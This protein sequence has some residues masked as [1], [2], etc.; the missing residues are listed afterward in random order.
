MRG[1]ARSVEADRRVVRFPF[2]SVRVAVFRRVSRFHVV[3]HMAR[4]RQEWRST[5][6]SR[7]GAAAAWVDL[8]PSMGWRGGCCVVA[9]TGFGVPTIQV[10]AVV[11]DLVNS[12][13]WK[14]VG[15]FV[16]ENSLVIQAKHSTRRDWGT[17]VMVIASTGVFVLN[18]G[19]QS[20]VAQQNGCAVMCGAGAIAEGEAACGD[21]DFACVTSVDCPNGEACEGGWCVYDDTFDGGCAASIPS[22]LPI[23]C[24]QEYCGSA[25]TF[26]G[27]NCSCAPPEDVTGDGVFDLLDLMCVLDALTGDF[28]TCPMSVVDVAPCGGNGKVNL[29]DVLAVVGAI[30]GLPGCCGPIPVGRDADWYELVLATDTLITWSGSAEFLARYQ[31]VAA[32]LPGA[33]CSDVAVVAD[34]VAAPCEPG[35]VSAC[36]QAGTYFLGISPVDPLGV[37]CDSAY[38]VRADCDS[39]ALL[40]GPGDGDCCDS[41]GNGTAGCNDGSCCSLVC[42][43]QPSCCS[44]EWDASCAALAKGM[45]SACPA[46][47]ADECVNA[48]PVEVPS[49]SPG[50]TVGMGIDVAPT[51]SNIGVDSPGVWYSVMGTGN[52]LSASICGSANYDSKIS[53]YCAGCDTLNCISGN[54]DLL[55]CGFTSRVNWCSQVGTEYLILVH[56]AVGDSGDFVLDVFDD[57]A[58]CS[59]AP[60]CGVAICG[61]GV[62]GFG[63]QCDDGNTTPGDGCDATCMLEPPPNDDCAN[64]PLITEADTP[65][66]FDNFAASTDGVSHT[67]CLF[68]GN[69][70]IFDDVW[71]D[72]VA[73][74]TGTAIVTTCDSAFDTKVAVYDGCG[75]PAG[76]PA[77]IGCD[78]DTCGLQSR[79][80][81]AATQG[82]CYKIRV[83]GGVPTEMGVGSG[84]LQITC[85]SVIPEGACCID[86]ACDSTGTEANCTAA[87]GIW[88]IGQSCPQF[89]CPAPNDEC[90]GRTLLTCGTAT[91]VDTTNGT[92]N[93]NDPPGSCWIGAGAGSVFL[94][95]VADA[96][97][98]RVRTDSA[99]AIGNAVDSEYVVFA[100]DQANPCDQSLWT[101]VGCSEDDGAG[102]LGDICVTGLTV[103]DR[104][105]IELGSFASGFQGQYTVEINCPCSPG[106]DSPGR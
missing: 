105:I 50:T 70:Q 54:D 9:S 53:A 74:C 41:V 59:T 103:G 47:P 11:A 93:A 96:S 3:R 30:R 36:V 37:A 10:I 77:K 78:D 55:G 87:G 27:G 40:C 48:T 62:V 73:E 60:D 65:L 57:G 101:Q 5:G 46:P 33:E 2:L 81:F 52:T 68:G 64:A 31:I 45:C 94:E 56:G 89:V 38:T 72:H 20:S 67:T 102:L 79:V 76:D 83:G 104:Y 26:C 95:F 16:G 106:P 14:L 44:V 24:G 58:A 29:F 71:F 86:G 75:C 1:S 42:D 21:F 43:V 100:V 23:A 12:G 17:L 6:Q 97:S 7:E 80:V 35:S 84:V 39:C 92:T 25:G 4:F 66:L 18:S 15:V 32:G 19:A 22:F 90:D 91:V 8:H 34:V 51:C 28:S 13:D 61:D 98:A 88:T 85:N 99:P 69:T 82:S 49:S 63:E